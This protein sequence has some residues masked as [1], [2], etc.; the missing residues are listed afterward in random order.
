[1]RLMLIYLVLA[2][3]VGWM[4]LRLPTSFLPQEDQGNIL[5]NIQLPPGATQER[6]RAVVEQAEAFML[7]Q[8]EV[9]SMVAVMGFS[10]SGQG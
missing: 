6:T 3:V 4:Y 5:L 2:A 10:F 1:G 7:K 8:P 9:K